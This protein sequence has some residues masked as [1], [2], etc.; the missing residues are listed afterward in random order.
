MDDA[1][2]R[3]KGGFGQDLPA[4]TY[5]IENGLLAVLGF[6]RHTSARNTGESE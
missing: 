3:P 6:G 4:R 5:Q 2:F 1:V